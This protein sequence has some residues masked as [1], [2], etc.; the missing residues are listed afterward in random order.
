[1]NSILERILEDKNV[2]VAQLRRDRSQFADVP[3]PPP[4]RN[5]VKALASEGLLSV[6]AEVKKASP[7]KGV[8]RPDFDPVA[9][10]EHYRDAGADAVSVL[11]DVKYF[12]G[13][14]GYLMTVRAAIPLPV[15]RKDFIID[16]IQVEQTAALGADAMLLIVAALDDHR[17]ADLQAAADE[18][19]VATLIEIHDRRELDRAMRVGP[20]C[21]GINNRN[22]STFVTDIAVTVDIMPYL[23]GEV[24]AVSESGIA[25]REDALRVRD[26]GVKAILV[27]ESLMREDDPSTLLRELKV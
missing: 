18:L 14:P 3:A 24:V 10:A 21:I 13:D 6:I 19:G 25:R 27:G 1:M 2:E 4:R 23:P 22:L 16:T 12:M 17:L 20:R 8:I 15:L 5:F 11:T 26:A 7:S 9:I